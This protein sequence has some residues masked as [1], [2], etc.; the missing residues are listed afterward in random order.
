M[1]L[2]LGSPLEEHKIIYSE[3]ELKMQLRHEESV[4]LHVNSVILS[5]E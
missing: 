5:E 3:H 2:I 4:Y 1:H